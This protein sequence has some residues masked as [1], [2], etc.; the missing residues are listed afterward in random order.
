[1]CVTMCVSVYEC[2]LS[3]Y[4]FVRVLSM[5]RGTWNVPWRF[6]EVREPDHGVGPLSDDKLRELFGGHRGMGSSW[7]DG[8]P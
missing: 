3:V 6:R 8:N 2:E 1:M 7:C 5:H 4:A